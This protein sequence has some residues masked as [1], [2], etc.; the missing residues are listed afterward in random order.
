M[1]DK[2]LIAAKAVEAG[3]RLTVKS[4]LNPVLWLCAIVTVPS[5]I[6]F[7]F[8]MNPPTW[9]VALAV[10][11]VAAAI[12]GFFFLLFF[13]R[14][15]L[16]SEEYQLKKQSLELIQEMGDKTPRV[17]SAD[18]LDALAEPSRPMLEEGREEEDAR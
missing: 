14:D 10:S 15:K 13:D 4:A 18:D 5:F 3:T 6:S 2:T 7:G 11:P 16:Q 8:V 12:F 17:M 1:L 9:W